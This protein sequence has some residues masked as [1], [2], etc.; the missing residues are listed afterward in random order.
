MLRKATVTCLVVARVE[1]VLEDRGLDVVADV[2][3]FLWYGHQPS[4]LGVAVNLFPREA[5]LNIAKAIAPLGD[6]SVISC[7]L[8]NDNAGRTAFVKLQQE[9]DDKVMDKSAL[10]PNHKDLND[11]LV[12]ITPKRTNKLKL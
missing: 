10:Y 7:Y 1:A 6:Y 4:P 2:K 5:V 8:D 9:L 3:P 12:S 11:Y